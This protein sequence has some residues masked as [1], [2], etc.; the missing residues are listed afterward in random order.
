MDELHGHC[1]EGRVPL[2]SIGYAGTERLFGLAQ[3]VLVVAGPL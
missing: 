3:L 1:E 2:D